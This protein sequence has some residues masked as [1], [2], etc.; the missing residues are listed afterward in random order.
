[1]KRNFKIGCILLCAALVTGCSGRDGSS[2]QDAEV[3]E[4]APVE[5][6]DNGGNGE[7]TDN[8]GNEKE[9]GIAKAKEIALEDAKLK[10]SDVQF[11]KEGQ[12]T[13]DGRTVY[14]IEF[15]NGDKE[16]D[17]EIDAVSGNIVSR[18]YEIENH[19][20]PSGEN[21]TGNGSAIT[22]KEAKNIALK[23]AGLKEKDGTW[24]KEKE[25]QDDG[26]MTYE[27][28]FVSGEMEYEFEIDAE[29]GNILDFDKESVYD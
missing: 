28:E 18:D 22:L 5:G 27:L 7:G 6:V 29:T 26:R 21:S 1:M 24:K 4:T 20:E 9:I 3:K 16:Y 19:K 2:V 10:E 8:G 23:K 11:T 12:D 13:E 14:E 17:Y 25:D 15:Y